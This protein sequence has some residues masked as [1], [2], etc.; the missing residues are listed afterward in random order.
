MNELYLKYR[1]KGVFQKRDVIRDFPHLPVKSI[2]DKIYRAKKSKLIK[3]VPGRRSIY[4][5]VEPG[6]D[7]DSAQPDPFQL[8][9]NLAPEAIICYASALVA[10]GK[11]HSI[12][13]T[14][15]L[16]SE[17]RFRKLKYMGIEYQYVMLPKKQV[18]I[19]LS[20]RYKGTPV[21][22]TTIE[23]TLIDCLRSLRYSG[24]FE[25][26]YKSYEGVAYLNREK[27]QNCLKYFSSPLLKARVGF[28][29]DLFKDRWGIPEEFFTNLRRYIPKNPDYF[30]GREK[31]GGILVRRWNLIVP[32]EILSLGDYD[33]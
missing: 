32:K 4:Y 10:L 25:H 17:N 9:A 30:L 33:D 23:R 5:I 20:H 7:Y 3:G 22:I 29:V 24:G 6:S 11:S 13:N 16:A 19:Q 14:M 21:R 27:L 15:Y 12:F 18:G 8:A 31:K 2:N 28:F 1:A 26:F